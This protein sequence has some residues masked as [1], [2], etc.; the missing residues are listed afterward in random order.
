MN[1]AFTA[2]I[3]NKVTARGYLDE[4]DQLVMLEPEGSGGGGA[5]RTVKM[6]LVNDINIPVIG[7]LPKIAQGPG[8]EGEL[9]IVCINNGN[10][11]NGVTDLASTEAG[12]AIVLTST[13]GLQVSGAATLDESG[14]IIYTGDFTITCVEP[15]GEG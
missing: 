15:E 5:L 10:V 13:A 3:N 9:F 14:A 7:A 1:K 11:N 12:G 2:N 6:T 4:N 8:S